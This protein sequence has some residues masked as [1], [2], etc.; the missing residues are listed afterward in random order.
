M[1]LDL[2]AEQW[3]WLLAVLQRL[4]A[5]ETI[6][7]EE[8]RALETYHS[9]EYEDYLMRKLDRDAELTAFEQSYLDNVAMEFDGKRGRAGVIRSGQ[10]SRATN[11]GCLGELLHRAVV[12]VVQIAVFLLLLFVAVLIV[13]TIISGREAAK[14]TP[15]PVKSAAEVVAAKAAQLRA[16]KQAAQ[17]AETVERQLATSEPAPK[18]KK[19]KPAPP[20]SAWRSIT[21]TGGDGRPHP[22]IVG[23][24]SLFG[25]CLVIRDPRG[26]CLVEIQSPRGDPMGG[27]A[28]WSAP[29]T[30]YGGDAIRTEQ[31]LRRG[32]RIA[33]MKLVDDRGDFYP[34]RGRELLDLLLAVPEDKEI[35]LLYPRAG[36]SNALILVPLRGLQAALEGVADL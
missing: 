8:R 6:T 31:W 18:P 26:A 16:A 21:Y 27:L 19:P 25:G 13:R 11:R 20:P 36:K 1:K 3:A 2:T 7:R 29:V 4:D 9:A 22:A 35:A 34:A 32:D 24:G 12:V 17:K 33:N 15:P 14:P 30:V 10:K 5:G 23:D 28:D